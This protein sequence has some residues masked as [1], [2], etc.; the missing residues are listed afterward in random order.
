M[1]VRNL[2]KEKRNLLTRVR[3]V[4]SSLRRFTRLKDGTCSPDLSDHRSSLGA[5]RPRQNDARAQGRKCAGASFSSGGPSL[6]AAA[7]AGGSNDEPALCQTPATTPTNRCADRESVAARTPTP[8]MKSRPSAES[9]EA[10]FRNA[11]SSWLHG[12]GPP[13]FGARRRS[14]R[15][16]LGH[17][18]APSSHRNSLG[19]FARRQTKN[20]AGSQRVQIG[21]CGTVNRSGRATSLRS[22]TERCSMRESEI[23]R[24]SGSLQVEH[25]R[26]LGWYSSAVASPIHQTQTLRPSRPEAG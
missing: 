14:H 12:R 16:A 7:L 5:T 9:G 1:S 11:A 17:W 22:V 23:W 13:A 8:S 20:Q 3:R 26:W 21:W 25:D 6:A 10:E 4:S 18:D 15:P 2:T 19:T 24:N